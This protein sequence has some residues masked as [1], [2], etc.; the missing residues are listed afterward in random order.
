[1]VKHYFYYLKNFDWI[2]L[3]SVLLLVSFGLMAIYTIGLGGQGNSL[4][5]FKKQAILAIIG[6]AILFVFAFLDYKILY[7]YSFYLYILAILLLVIVFF[8]GKTVNGTTG[9]L[10]F[11]NLTIQPVEFAKLVLIIVLAKFFSKHSNNV[12]Q[13][14]NLSFSIILILPIILLILLQPDFGSAIILLIIWFV[15]L[16]FFGTRKR[17]YFS[18]LLF[19]ILLFLFSWFFLFKP[20]QKQRI[21]TFINP[22]TNVLAQDYNVIQAKIAVGAGGFSG[23]ALNLSSQS[24]LKFLPSAS[25][26]F[27]YAVI[28]EELGFLGVSLLFTLFIVFYI[29]LIKIMFKVKDGFG[30]YLLIG[31]FILFFTQTFINIGMNIGIAPVVGISLPFLS[32]GGS[33]LIICLIIIGIVENIYLKSKIS[34]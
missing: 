25:N 2:L 4:I 31:A 23:R 14:K 3:L 19:S 34:F 6:F 18:I 16:F 33:F 17:Y 27:I 21:K 1:M 15:M 29:R 10:G 9:W 13:L 11:K 7:A 24:Q 32:S 28:C 30:L 22:N 8:W 26:D 20:Y 5:N 12:D